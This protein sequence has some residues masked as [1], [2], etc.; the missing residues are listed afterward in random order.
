MPHN[1]WK[2]SFCPITFSF[3]PDWFTECRE[4][5][6]FLKKKKMWKYVGWIEKTS[7]IVFAPLP[8]P[9]SM[10]SVYTARRASSP[11]GSL[12]ERCSSR[13]H[14]REPGKST[15]KNFQGASNSISSMRLARSFPP[16]SPPLFRVFHG[17]ENSSFY[18]LGYGTGVGILG[19]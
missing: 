6:L 9:S 12:G 1:F 8:R 14:Q 10:C 3:R 11:L 17:K 13:E 15:V 18:R 5:I 16:L 4:L 7:W 2:S 19:S